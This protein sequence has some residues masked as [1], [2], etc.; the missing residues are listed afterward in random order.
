MFEIA[1]KKITLFNLLVPPSHFPL[2]PPPKKKNCSIL[3]S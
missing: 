3:F 2:P 1:N